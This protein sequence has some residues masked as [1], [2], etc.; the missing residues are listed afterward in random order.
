MCTSGTASIHTVCQIPVV[1]VYWQWVLLYHVACLPR[2]CISCRE[3]LA[4]TI[5]AACSRNLPRLGA[6][7]SRLA[8]ER[9]SWP[10]VFER[11]FYIYREVCFN[12][13]KQR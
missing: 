9:L 6:R 11:L 7:A 13:R 5:E 4:R 2:A 8:E 10:R 1:R 3:S 12:Y